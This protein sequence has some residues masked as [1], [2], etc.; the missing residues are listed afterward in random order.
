MTF[1]DTE[2]EVN[3]SKGNL[4]YLFINP[5]PA[6]PMLEI[7]GEFQGYWSFERLLRQCAFRQSKNVKL[8]SY[9]FHA[10]V[11]LGRLQITTI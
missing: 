5:A 1:Q 11:D 4:Q 3:K 7:R 10:S 9:F 2:D 6:L 8:L